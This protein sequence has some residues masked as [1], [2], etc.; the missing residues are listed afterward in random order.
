MEKTYSGRIQ[1]L[2]AA[3]YAQITLT[4]AEGTILRAGYDCSDRPLLRDCCGALCAV[5]ADKPAVDV[6]QMN[7]NAVYYN[8]ENDLPRDAL[9]LATIAVQAAKK[10][11]L[12]Y[13]KDNGL[14]CD[15]EGV[16]DC[17]K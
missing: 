6:M 7:N 12:A 9:Y 5:L 8:L 1:P 17:L 13:L 4:V 14:P 15:G 11:A 16:C 10:A 3:E 2:D